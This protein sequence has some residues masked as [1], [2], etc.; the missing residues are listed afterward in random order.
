MMLERECTLYSFALRYC[1]LLVRDVPDGEFADQPM[2]GVIHPAWVLGHLAFAADGA[3]LL[4]RASRACPREWRPLF[5]PGSAIVGDRQAY[6][7][8][9]ELLTAVVAGHSLVVDAAGRA[10][11]ELLNAPQRG[12]FYLEDF[13]TVGDMVAHLMTTHACLHLGQ[14]SA[15]R[16]MKGLPSALGI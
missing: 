3:A 13:P 16:Q 15:W 10:T 8:K 11:P 2:P 5:G 12:P 4:L 6:P 14:L 1:R 7:G 9:D